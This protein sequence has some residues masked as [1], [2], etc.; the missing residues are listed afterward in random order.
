LLRVITCPTCSREFL[1][2]TAQREF[3]GPANAPGECRDCRKKRRR[4]ARDSEYAAEEKRREAVRKRM[5][6]AQALLRE[7]FHE[8][9]IE[10]DAHN[11]AGACLKLL[12]PY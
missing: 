3:L 4:A 11:V 9:G 2:S 8:T 12:E 1:S 10:D 7:V 6:E 5:R